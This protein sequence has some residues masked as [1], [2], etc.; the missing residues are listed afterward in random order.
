MLNSWSRGLAELLQGVLCKMLGQL[1]PEFA[2]HHP[3][4]CVGG[5]GGGLQPQ[6]EILL[7]CCWWGL[8]ELLQGVL[9]QVLR[10]L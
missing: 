3:E 6:M 8:A 2:C 1:W 4:D 5:R 7:A 10:Q 9:R